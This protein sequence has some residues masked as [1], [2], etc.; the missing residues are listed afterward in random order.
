[1]VIGKELN[2]LKR[3]VLYYPTINLPETDWL[4]RMILYYDKVGTITPTTYK[5]YPN[6][7][8]SYTLDFIKE[9]LVEQVFP[10]EYICGEDNFVEPF[11]IYIES[12]GPELRKRLLSFRPGEPSFFLRSMKIHVSKIDRIGKYLINKNLAVK[13]DNQW[14]RVEMATG[15]DYMSYL[16]AYIGQVDESG[17]TPI[18]DIT[19]P[20]NR[21]VKEKYINV[22]TENEI[23]P[24]R[25]QVLNNLFPSPTKPLSARNILEFKFR[26]N[27]KLQE[28]RYYVENS[29]I[30]IININNDDLRQ[31]KLAIF[32]EE[33]TNNIEEM[34]A[35]MKEFGWFETGTAKL[36]GIASVA[37]QPIGVLGA[38]SK[39]LTASYPSYPEQVKPTPLLYAAVAQKE[40][41]SK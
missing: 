40:L 10:Q 33:S 29:I 32:N 16:A 26:H 36:Y 30:D 23:Y 27:D 9:G 39:A 41:L 31:R 37:V 8:N 18:S 20:I 35:V 6:N 24:I 11:E 19:A 2:P 38:V 14:N 25:I 7:F 4:T 21:L 12:L 28:L 34:K 5:R 15:L 13:I 17:F 22:R 3:N 1:M